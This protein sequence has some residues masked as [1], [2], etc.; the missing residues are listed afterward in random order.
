[1]VTWHIHNLKYTSNHALTVR[2]YCNLVKQ[3]HTK[4]QK[5]WEFVAAMLECS[6][7]T[8]TLRFCASRLLL[9]ILFVTWC[10]RQ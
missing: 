9:P 8:S 1:M 7:T 6:R 2:K 5:V 4:S 3:R 10:F